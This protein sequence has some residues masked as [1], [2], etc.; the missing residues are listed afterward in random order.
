MYQLPVSKDPF[1]KQSEVVLFDENHWSY[2]Q[3]RYRIT[4]REL[5]ITKFIC[6]GFNN[7]QI[8]NALRIKNGTVKTHLRN[9][10]RRVRVRNKILL[11][12]RFL[13]D[14]NNLHIGS[15][16]VGPVIPIYKKA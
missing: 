15:D 13:A 9:V 3:K 5:Q 8:A 4:P 7:E 10:Y 12:L 6:Q 16:S 1:L 14:I 11:L 2:L